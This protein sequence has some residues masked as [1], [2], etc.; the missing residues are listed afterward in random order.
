MTE[1]RRKDLLETQK[2]HEKSNILFLVLWDG[3]ATRTDIVMGVD[4]S[5]Q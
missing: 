5:R 3:V 4:L 2:T 1:L